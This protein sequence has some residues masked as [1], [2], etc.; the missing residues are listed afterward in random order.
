MTHT[1]KDT[2]IGRNDKMTWIQMLIISVHVTFLMRLCLENIL[3]VCTKRSGP[4][5]DMF[6]HVRLREPPS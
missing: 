3:E 2:K 6:R 1:K 4:C 5:S